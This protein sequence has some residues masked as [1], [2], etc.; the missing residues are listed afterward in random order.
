MMIEAENCFVYSAHPNLLVDLQ[1]GLYFIGRGL[2]KE[3][4]ISPDAD[5]N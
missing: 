3:S 1:W 4:S 2:E 5:C